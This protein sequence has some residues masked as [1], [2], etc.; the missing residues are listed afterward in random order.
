[1]NDEPGLLLC[2]WPKGE[3]PALP[4]VYSDEVWT[5]I[6]Y[7][8]AALL[9]YNG[10]VDE[11]L[12]I[13]R[14]VRERYA[15]YNR[16]PWEEEECGHHYARAMSSWSLLLA[17][18]G[19]EYSGVQKK[20]GFAPAIHPE[21]FR[22]FWSCG[23]GWGV[24]SQQINRDGYEAS[25]NVNYGSLKLKKIHLG[26]SGKV[27]KNILLKVGDQNIKADHQLLDGNLIFEFEQYEYFIYD[28]TIPHKNGWN[29]GGV[30]GTLGL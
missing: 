3:R 12:E 4:F 8:I 14:S 19:F 27:P 10:L 30:Y 1:L 29:N 11:G 20:I 18:A 24:F 7:Q 2:T 6:E 22:T 26:Y 25:L 9:I 16:N 15:G 13:V 5:G 23:S 17:L 21:D 28:Q